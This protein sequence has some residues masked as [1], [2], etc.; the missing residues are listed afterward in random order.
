[1]EP[2]FTVGHSTRTIAEFS[3]LLHENRIQ[4]LVDVRRYP[5]SRRYPH[6]GRE[7]LPVFLQQAGI[8]YVHEDALGGRRTP[9]ADSPNEVWRNAQFRGYADHMDS[10]E[11]R[12]ALQ[13]LIE[14]A[15]TTRQVIMCA[16]A[17]PWRCH[18][19]LIA[20][21][22]VARGV[23]VRHIIQAGSVKEHALNEN[24]RVLADGH[25][26]YS[27]AGPQIDLL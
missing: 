23:D 1:M 13:R 7:P 27:S 22:L 14:G 4:R 21:A 10:P 3:A 15:Q 20:D 19:Q 25:L 18:R 12:A 26:V 9:R 24:A 8:E 6:F 2:V 11:F 17:V 5:G 16:E